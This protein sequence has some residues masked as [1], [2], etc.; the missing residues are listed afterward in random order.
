MTAQPSHLQPVDTND[1]PEYPISA[2]DRLD[3]HFFIPW[4]LKRWRK[5]E[6]R[7]LAEPEVGWGA[8]CEDAHPTFRL[9]WRSEY[10]EQPLLSSR[11]HSP[12]SGSL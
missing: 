6:F 10:F 1:L 4:N 12:C 3:S 11:R 2:D 5:S 8:H 9:S 7:Q